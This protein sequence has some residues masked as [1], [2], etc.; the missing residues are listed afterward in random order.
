MKARI[1]YFTSLLFTALTLGIYL[2]H[3]LSMKNKMSMSGDEYLVAQQIYHGWSYL[4]IIVVF[5]LLSLFFQ[6][7]VVRHQEA[8]C[9]YC[10]ASF[11]SLSA[12]QAIFWLYT[13]PVNQ[14]TNNWMFLPV[15]WEELRMRWEYSHAAG[16]AFAL[17]AFIALSLS[18]IRGIKKS[19]IRLSWKKPGPAEPAVLQ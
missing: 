17:I 10:R 12:T 3:V 7:I 19:A 4:G 6:T 14:Q 18:V 9:N 13:Y 11:L 8:M 5:G 16:A 2:A 15:N 1:I